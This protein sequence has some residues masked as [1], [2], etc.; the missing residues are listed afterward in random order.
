MASRLVASSQIPNVVLF[1]KAISRL[2][3][4]RLIAISLCL[5][6]A[7]T[8]HVEAAIIIQA[9]D[10]V[11]IVHAVVPVAV[12]AAHV[13]NRR[14]PL[15]LGVACELEVPVALPAI[16]CVSERV[17]TAAVGACI[18]KRV[19]PKVVEAVCLAVRV[20]FLGR[21]GVCGR[22]VLVEGVVDTG[23]LVQ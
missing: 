4:S 16:H 19:I 5:E 6:I 11:P 3:A 12:I 9:F 8:E 23:A 22:I 18:L 21:G 7:L 15:R 1:A 13:L 10:S 2:V 14:L 17:I 20:V